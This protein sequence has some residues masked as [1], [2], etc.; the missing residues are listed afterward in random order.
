MNL[1][2]KK[3]AKKSQ[4][5]WFSP[6]VAKLGVVVVNIIPTYLNLMLVS[7][8]FY[9][10]NDRLLT[11]AVTPRVIIGAPSDSVVH[12]IVEMFAFDTFGAILVANTGIVKLP[13]LWIRAT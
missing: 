12:F 8:A 1:I 2:T 13:P 11:I 10:L 3:H 6:I 4:D 5:V 9:V 7:G